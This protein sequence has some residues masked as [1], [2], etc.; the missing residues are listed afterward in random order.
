[1]AVHKQ[2]PMQVTVDVD[3]GIADT[4]RHLNTIPG[5]RT[6]ASCQGTIGEGGA[7]PYRPYVLVS[8]PDDETFARLKGEYDV[9]E[10]GANNGQV[11][12]IPATVET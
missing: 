1:M 5:V 3:E 7:E 4:V 9:S 10:V 6:H 11:H 8:W 12:P 2:I